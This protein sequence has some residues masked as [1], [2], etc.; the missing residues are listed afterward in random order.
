MSAAKFRPNQDWKRPTAKLSPLAGPSIGIVALSSD[1]AGVRDFEDFLQPID[2]LEIFSTRIPMGP[3]ATPESLAAMGPYLTQATELLV[4]GSRLDVVAFSC[5]SGTLAIGLKEVHRAVRK[6]RP[7][8]CVTT[9]I[10]AGVL[11]LTAL[12]VSRISLLTPY[13]EITAQLVADYFESQA[14]EILGRGTFA[15]EGDLQMNRVTG[16]SIAAGAAEIRHPHAEALFISCTGL[17]TFDAIVRIEA[18]LGIPCV[19]SNQALA[20]NSLRLAGIST[21]LPDRGALF[22]I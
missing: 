13:L 1:R 8:C 19:T 14:I 11:G 16:E 22:R 2:D 20:W 10:E 3:V 12:G 7:E 17:R 6:A 5:T 4:P 9:P 15:L 18:E 21:A